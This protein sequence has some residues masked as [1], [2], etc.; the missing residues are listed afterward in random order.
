[1]LP[2][3]E[4]SFLKRDFYYH[5]IMGCFIGRLDL[6]TASTIGMWTDVKNLTETQIYNAHIRDTYEELALH[7]NELF[8][9]YRAALPKVRHA[10]LEQQVCFG[11]YCLAYHK[12]NQECSN[13]RC[14]YELDS[15]DHIV[16]QQCSTLHP[17][18]LDIPN[19]SS[20]E[21]VRRLYSPR[22]D[23]TKSDGHIE[24]QG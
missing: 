16:G 9:S 7:D 5:P 18:D 22:T 3:E 19:E 24:F 1:L 8:H 13:G 6:S 2:I 4:V 21:V 10:F 23:N 17:V 20:L 12:H 15:Y 11:K 14:T